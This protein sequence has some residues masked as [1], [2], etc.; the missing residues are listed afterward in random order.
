MASVEECYGCEGSGEMLDY[1]DAN[2][3]SIMK[4]CGVCGGA[5]VVLIN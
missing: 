1:V 3:D 2:G 4:N 5:C